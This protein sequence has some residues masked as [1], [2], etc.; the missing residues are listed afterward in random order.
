MPFY[1]DG[2]IRYFRFHSLE[3]PG[4]RHAIFTRRGGVSPAPWHSLNL[5]GSVGDDIERVRRNREKALNVLGIDPANIYDV[6]QVHSDRVVISDK[7]LA[8][9]EPH[10]KADAI[11]TNNP[12]VTLMMR[13]ADCVPILLFDPVKRAVG[14]AHAGWIGTINKIAAKTVTQMQQNFGSQPEDMLAAIGP[15][16]GPDHYPVGDDVI[17][18]VVLSFKNN[19]EQLITQRNRKSF[20]DLW[21]ANKLILNEVGLSHIEIASICTSCNLA[22]WYSHRGEHGKTGRFGAVVG[23]A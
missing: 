23:L 9:D 22:D 21:K 8:K 14:I 10:V 1:Q 6:Y 5:G 2:P 19:A 12:S 15:S 17:A 4:I 3:K 7:P 18:Q 13:F 20:F 11:I 16:I